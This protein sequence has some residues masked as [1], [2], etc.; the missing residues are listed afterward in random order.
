[1]L[2]PSDSESDSDDALAPKRRRE[3][4]ALGLLGSGQGRDDDADIGRSVFCPRLVDLR[5]EWGRSYA[6]FVPCE[7]ALRGVVAG[8]A[9]GEVS[10]A[11]APTDKYQ[12]CESLELGGVVNDAD[13]DTDDRLPAAWV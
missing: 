10:Q 4:H 5:G 13:A 1:V 8:W 7:D 11:K 9:G 2:P 3:G 12:A 6:G